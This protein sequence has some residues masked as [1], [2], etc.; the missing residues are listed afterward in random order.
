MKYE[1]RK[2]FRAVNG[3]HGYRISFSE[4]EGIVNED[5]LGILKDAGFMDVNDLEPGDIVLLKKFRDKEGNEHGYAVFVL[6]DSGSNY[7]LP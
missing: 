1:I 2:Y 7:R 6:D 3:S 5:G 4:S